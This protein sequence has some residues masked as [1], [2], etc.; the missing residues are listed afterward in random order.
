MRQ[1]NPSGH[2]VNHANQSFL[3][4]GFL[5]MNLTAESIGGD[6]L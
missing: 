3:L 1:A 5:C 4:D 6:V 2:V